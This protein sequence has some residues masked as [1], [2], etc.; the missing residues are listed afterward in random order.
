MLDLYLIRHAESELNRFLQIIGGR[1]NETPLSENG[2]EQAYLLGERLSKI[3]FTVYYS[4]PAVRSL[5]TARIA[6]GTLDDVVQS[7][8]L[9]ELDQGDW[10]GK[11]R[12]EI[13]TPEMLAR[14]N[15]DNWNFSAPN[16]ESQRAVEERMLC[17]VNDNLLQYSDLSCCVFTH[18]LAI[19]CLLRSVM[20][21]SPKITY[22]IEIENT[23][24]TRLKYSDRGWYVITI[25]DTAHLK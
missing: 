3:P 10:E 11:L 17:F 18:G 21:F 16:G 2:R 22:K 19:K 6:H 13:Y 4:S 7:P 1:S 14:I 25:N 20:D 15:A 23:S 24:I 12:T 9:L 8:L 5:E